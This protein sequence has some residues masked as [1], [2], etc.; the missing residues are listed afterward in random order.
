MNKA[1]HKTH[2]ELGPKHR[3][4]ESRP[5]VNT[6]SVARSRQSTNGISQAPGLRAV[7]PSSSPV[8]PIMISLLVIVILTGCRSQQ[9]TH[10][11]DR[12]Q[13]AVRNADIERILQ[14]HAFPYYEIRDGIKYKY[15]VEELRSRLA[16]SLDPDLYEVYEF[17]NRRV[18]MTGADEAVVHCDLEA[19]I[20]G[21]SGSP[22]LDVA[23]LELLLVREDGTW[24]IRE[25]WELQ[26]E[27]SRD[28]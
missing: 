4:V 25:W 13:V 2:E 5:A 3:V 18:E 12:Y 23:K 1:L 26:P 19:I 11:L 17:K 14:Y 16:H 22:I 6:R 8:T 27:S 28:Q 24:R 20:P 21:T 15:S 9:V 10:I 7:C